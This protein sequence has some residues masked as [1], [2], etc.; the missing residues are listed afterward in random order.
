MI[1][2]V[3]KFCSGRGAFLPGIAEQYTNSQFID[4]G[5]TLTSP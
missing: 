5:K 2:M 1:L 3:L 4:F